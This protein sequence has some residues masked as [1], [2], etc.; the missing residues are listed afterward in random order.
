MD[1][2]TGSPQFG[3]EPEEPKQIFRPMFHFDPSLGWK[4]LC[5]VP[6]CFMVVTVMVTVMVTLIVING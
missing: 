4:L 6:W 3:T 5:E 2:T 1:K